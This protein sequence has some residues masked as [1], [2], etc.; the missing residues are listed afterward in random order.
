MSEIAL[1]GDNLFERIRWPSGV[2]CPRCGEEERI[3]KGTFP[4]RKS[5]RCGAPECR[6]MFSVTAGT[7]LEDTRLDLDKWAAGFQLLARE[8]AGR[9]AGALLAEE[10]DVTGKTAWRIAGLLR[11][12][13]EEGLRVLLDP[14]RSDIEPLLLRDF[15]GLNPLRE[16][17]VRPQIVE[18]LAEAP[19]MPHELLG[20]FDPIRDGSVRHHVRILRK[21]GLVESTELGRLEASDSTKLA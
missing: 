15:E 6:Y 5:Y 10:L 16:S 12:A 4:K 11:V 17:T 20:R 14:N 19:L 18:T 9:G 13:L 7:A 8:G 3:G 2:R 1:D 21:A